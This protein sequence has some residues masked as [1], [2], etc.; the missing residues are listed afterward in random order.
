VSRTI[1]VDGGTI[2]VRR[3]P[4]GV[5]MVSLEPL[6]GRWRG[7]ILKH[8]PATSKQDDLHAVL[9]V[10]AR[11]VG[12]ARG[13]LAPV[14]ACQLCASD[15]LTGADSSGLERVRFRM[16]ERKPFI[17]AVLRALPKPRAQVRFSPGALRPSET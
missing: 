16:V 9:G 7:E 10:G 4:S 14:T 6:P 15:H 13:R 11:R 5:W 2:H 8:V 1:V 17:H 3:E 12:A